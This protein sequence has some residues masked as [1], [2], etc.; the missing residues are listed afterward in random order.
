MMTEEELKAIISKANLS[1]ADIDD[2][3][4]RIMRFNEKDRKIL[5]SLMVF[6]KEYRA[7]TDPMKLMKYFP[8]ISTYR[9]DFYRIF[10]LLNW[11]WLATRINPMIDDII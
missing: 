10:C 4:A 2:H 1:K 6:A 11:Q 3:F 9:Y 8:S 7:G 5:A